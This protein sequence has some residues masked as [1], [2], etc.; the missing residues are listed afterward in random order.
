MKHKTAKYATY[1]LI[2][3]YS[4]GVLGFTIPFTHN[5]FRTLTPFALLLSAA[6]II[7]FHKPRFNSKTLLVFGLIYVVSFVAEAIGVNTGLL[8]G[9]YIY[10]KGLGPKI[11]ET[12]LMIGLNWLMLVY[13]TKVITDQLFQKEIIQLIAGPLMMVGYDLVM[14]QAAPGLDMWS[15]NGGTIPLQNYLAWF[16]FAFLFHLLIRKSKVS[17]ANA[18]AAPVFIIQFLFFVIL[19]VFFRLDLS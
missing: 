5:F 8:F 7:W 17:F 4:V 13:C 10:G 11:F 9:D 2:L 16:G 6:F 12:P 14:E 3:F 19:V 18:L 15:W 1:F